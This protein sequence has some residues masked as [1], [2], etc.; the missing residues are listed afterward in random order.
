MAAGKLFRRYNHLRMQAKICACND[1]LRF[2]HLAGGN[3]PGPAGNLR[4][5]FNDCVRAEF[6]QT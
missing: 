1:C 2:P 4:Q 6:Y 5:A 3:L